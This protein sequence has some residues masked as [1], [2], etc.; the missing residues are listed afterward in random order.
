MLRKSFTVGACA[1]LMTFAA[2]L[3]AAPAAFAAVAAAGW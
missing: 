1:A 2:A 3:V